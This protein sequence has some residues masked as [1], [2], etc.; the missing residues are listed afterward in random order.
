MPYKMPDHFTFTMDGPENAGT[1]GDGAELGRIHG[2]ME[3]HGVHRIRDEEL[4]A[5]IWNCLEVGRNAWENFPSPAG[6]FSRPEAIS[7]NCCGRMGEYSGSVQPH[8]ARYRRLRYR[9]IKIPA[10]NL[11]FDCKIGPISIHR[12]VRVPEVCIAW[13]CKQSSGHPD[14]SIWPIWQTIKSLS[15]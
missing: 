13:T 5:N 1:I 2:R 9:C 4:S 14:A 12:Q 7:K 11:K 8:D 15:V 6:L 3:S 10:R